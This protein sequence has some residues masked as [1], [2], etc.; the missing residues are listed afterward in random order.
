M[1]KE[2]IKKY[3]RPI[4][5]TLVGAIIGLLYYKFVGCSTGTCVITSNPVSSML[6]MGLVGFL[7]SG[8]F[9]KG[10]GGTCNM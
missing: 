7:L 6:Y 4:I 5:F 3:I 10:C 8:A 9:C 2:K 1:I